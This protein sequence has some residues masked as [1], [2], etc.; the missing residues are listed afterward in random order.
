MS[1]KEKTSLGENILYAILVALTCLG[2]LTSCEVEPIDDPVIYEWYIDENDSFEPQA[3]IISES[4]YVEIEIDTLQSDT[5]FSLYAEANEMPERKRYNGE[6][7]IWAS[8]TTPVTY[9]DTNFPIISTASVRFDYPKFHNGKPSS[10]Q[11]QKLDLWTKQH[12]GPI[13]SSMVKQRDTIPV[14]MDVSFD[15]D[16]HVRDTLFVVLQPK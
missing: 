15:G 11:P 10:Y 6:N 3:I 5:Y 9:P 1:N 4:K 13:N 16:Y 7:N 12:V 14:Y 2:L 8:F